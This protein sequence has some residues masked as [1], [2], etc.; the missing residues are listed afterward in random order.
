MKPEIPVV[1]QG[2]V[3]TLFGDILPHLNAEYSM[4]N[5]SLMAM[6]LFMVAEEFDRAADIRVAEN[7]EMR[8][9]FA[10]AGRLIDDASLAARL[11]E[12]SKGKDASLRIT[13]LNASNDALKAL[14]IELQ[15]LVEESKAPWAP[16]LEEKIWDYIIAAAERRKLTF[17]SLG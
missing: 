8:A 13:A 6:S 14:L 17:P 2:H 7:A 4:G 11:T 12:A 16:A 3:G 1:M 5:T 10:E 15:T 9:L